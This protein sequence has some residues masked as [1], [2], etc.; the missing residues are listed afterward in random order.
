MHLIDQTQGQR[1]HQQRRMSSV[2]GV[3]DTYPLYNLTS[4]TQHLLGSNIGHALH[5]PASS[6]NFQ[7]SSL[8]N[9]I[10]PLPQKFQ[11]EDI[12]Y[13]ETKGALAIPDTELRNELL[14]CYVL[15]VHTYMPLLDLDDFLRA[16]V[17]NENSNQLSLLLFQAVMFAGSAF[18]PSGYLSAAGFKSRK[19]ARKTFFQRARV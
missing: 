6:N 3:P 12:D 10:R 7:S 9:F 1:E 11:P 2:P 18:I 4:T 19:A 5:S 16:I 14:R 17:R 15:Y 8:P 13:L